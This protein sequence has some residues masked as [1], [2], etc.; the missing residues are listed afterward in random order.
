MN[1][2]ALITLIMA[3]GMVIIF[4]TYFFYKVLTMPQKEE[5]DSYTDNDV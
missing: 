1:N 2:T 4:V 3:Q 5:P